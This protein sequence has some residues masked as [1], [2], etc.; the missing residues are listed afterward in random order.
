[1]HCST[2]GSAL[3]Q[4]ETRPARHLIDETSFA[5]SDCLARLEQNNVL[6][7]LNMHG[8]C[9]ILGQPA[10]LY[11]SSHP[12][13]QKLSSTLPNMLAC[14]CAAS[15]CPQTHQ[16]ASMQTPSYAAMV[17]PVLLA[18]LRMPGCQV[19]DGDMSGQP[20]SLHVCTGICHF[21]G[22]LAQ[23]QQGRLDAASDSFNHSSQACM[24][25]HTQPARVPPLSSISLI[26]PSRLPD[27]NRLEC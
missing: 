18:R 14:L 19:D 11:T 27:L 20:A 10:C 13:R 16:A 21:P 17:L 25:A 4:A 24:Q 26:L 15:M 6:H 23:T 7:I 22:M 2:P 9:C 5:Q 1:M 12:K 8:L 3:V